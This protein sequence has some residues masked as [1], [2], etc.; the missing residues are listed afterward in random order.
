MSGRRVG[1]ALLGDGS[2]VAYVAQVRDTF[3]EA[4]IPKYQGDSGFGAGLSHVLKAVSI[5]DPNEP[6]NVV[7]A[8]ADYFQHLR[9][10]AQ[11]PGD[12]AL[13]TTVVGAG[14]QMASAFNLAWESLEEH[15]NGIDYTINLEMNRST[16]WLIASRT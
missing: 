5:F 2:R 8:V 9:E 7:E 1:G 15:R 12:T 6:G 16:N 14:K 3:T 13:R 11:N 10:L 4:Q